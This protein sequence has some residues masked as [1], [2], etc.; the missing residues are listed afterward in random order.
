VFPAF[1]DDKAIRRIHLISND[2]VLSILQQ[3]YEIALDQG[4]RPGRARPEPKRAKTH[5]SEAAI[6]DLR[7]GG[8]IWILDKMFITNALTKQFSGLARH[9][10]GQK[11]ADRNK[12]A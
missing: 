3:K 7:P 11:G 8:S 5:A 6:F 1:L 12:A 4:M 9:S 10:N 2:H